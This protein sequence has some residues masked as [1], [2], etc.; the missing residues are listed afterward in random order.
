MSICV[1]PF[2][3]KENQ[4]EEKKP[5]S[6][7]P[8]PYTEKQIRKQKKEAYK[9][10]KS[11]TSKTNPYFFG[12]KHAKSVSPYSKIDFGGT[13]KDPFQQICLFTKYLMI[14]NINFLLIDDANR[15]KI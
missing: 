8:I 13:K 6:S 2:I 7:I 10:V 4:Y 15:L 11:A 9:K 5:F 14:D 1:P 12:E 3:N